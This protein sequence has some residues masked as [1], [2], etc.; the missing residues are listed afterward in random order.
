MKGANMYKEHLEGTRI[1]K[2][3]SHQSSRKHSFIND[4]GVSNVFNQPVESILVCTGVYNPQ[5]D[6][7]YNVR[8]IFNSPQMHFQNN[9]QHSFLPHQH[10][11]HHATPQSQIHFHLDEMDQQAAGNESSSGV[12]SSE[13]GDNLS[14]LSKS[15]S[16]NLDTCELSTA[17]ATPHSFISYFDDRL[18]LPDHIF[19]NLKHSVD[20][21]LKSNIPNNSLKQIS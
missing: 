8:K 14:E 16:D 5:N 20:Y 19:D 18:N 11:L 13:S 2:V 1:T 7:L 17:L 15:K 6:L 21:I 12:E 9:H 10:Q 3:S 4:V